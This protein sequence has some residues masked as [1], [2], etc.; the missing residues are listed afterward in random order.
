MVFSPLF[1]KTTSLFMV[2]SPLFYQ[3]TSVSMVFSPFFYKTP[4][5]LPLHNLSLICWQSKTLWRPMLNLWVKGRRI[6]SILHVHKVNKLPFC[7]LVNVQN[8]FAKNP[9]KASPT[10]ELFPSSVPSYLLIIS[11]KLLRSQSIFWSF[12]IFI[13]NYGYFY[14]QS[15][16]I[17]S[18]NALPSGFHL[19]TCF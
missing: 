9:L 12:S 19:W 8:R 5:L 11:R 18:S 17:P 4:S 15:Y 3:T 13:A 6:N 1:H 10:G 2:F 7:S 16:R 14:F